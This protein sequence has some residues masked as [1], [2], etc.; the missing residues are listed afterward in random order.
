MS[1]RTP[2]PLLEGPALGEAFGK[3]L[4]GPYAHRRGPRDGFDSLRP[5]RSSTGGRTR[6]EVRNRWLRLLGEERVPWALTRPSGRS[7]GMSLCSHRFLKI[8][9]EMY[10]TQ[11]GA[12]PTVS[13]KFI[14]LGSGPYL[15]FWFLGASES[16]SP[17]NLPGPLG[18]FLGSDF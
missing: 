17:A 2:Q 7:L 16:I 8:A 4:T 9:R 1:P 10:V 5:T 12:N 15:G 18:K 6:S 13:Q 14:D 3:R 11:W